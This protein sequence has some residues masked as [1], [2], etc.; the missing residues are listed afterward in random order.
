MLAAKLHR[1][2]ALP[3]REAQASD[4]LLQLSVDYRS[5]RGTSAVRPTQSV[6]SKSSK[7]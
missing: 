3:E 6:R 7:A 1:P 5:H 4:P 2:E